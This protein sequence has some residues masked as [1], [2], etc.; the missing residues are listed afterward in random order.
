MCTWCVSGLISGDVIST[1][2][3]SLPPIKALHPPKV[4]SLRSAYGVLLLELIYLHLWFNSPTNHWCGRNHCGSCNRSVCV[5]MCSHVLYM[6]VLVCMCMCVLNVFLV[7]SSSAIAGCVLIVS[8]VIGLAYLLW[9][10]KMT[11]IS[12]LGKDKSK[13]ACICWLNPQARTCTC[14]YKLHSITFDGSWC[15]CKPESE[16]RGFQHTV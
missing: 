10:K 8:C 13:W 9:R 1:Q 5:Y 2:I 15:V 6:F 11:A 4:I 12:I 3:Q 14:I 7:M 16:N